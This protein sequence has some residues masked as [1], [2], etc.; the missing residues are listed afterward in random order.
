MKPE[1]EKRLAVVIDGGRDQEVRRSTTVAPRRSLGGVRWLRRNGCRASALALAVGHGGSR[2]AR[3][4]RWGGGSERRAY[5][6]ATNIVHET[7]VKS[8]GA[9][10]RVVGAGGR[11]VVGQVKLC[12]RAIGN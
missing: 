12:G 4:G 8:R 6:P 11:G 10:R 3:K 7:E 1:C 9:S 2:C 5:S